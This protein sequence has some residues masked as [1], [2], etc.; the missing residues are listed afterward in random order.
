MGVADEDEVRSIVN[1]DIF[2]G[3]RNEALFGHEEWD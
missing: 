2:G 3:S 1:R